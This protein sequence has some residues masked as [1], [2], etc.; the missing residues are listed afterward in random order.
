MRQSANSF[1]KLVA[2]AAVKKLLLKPSPRV[3]MVN[4]AVAVPS[5]F[6]PIPCHEGRYSIDRHGRVFTHIGKRLLSLTPTNAG[7]LAVK[8]VPLGRPPEKTLV[9]YLMIRTFATDFPDGAFV[10]HKNRCRSDNRI[11]NLRP[12]TRRQQCQNKSAV[13]QNQITVFRGVI[14]KYID[15]A[16][17]FKRWVATVRMPGGKKKWSK[18]FI[19]DRE[20]AL[21][22]D[23]MA[24]EFHGEFAITNKSLGLL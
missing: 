21:E 20:A 1:Q 5:G 17:A 13:K 2:Q 19:T 22:Y 11:T 16:A 24:V 12:A 14:L 4:G 8:L 18:Y 7:Y 23:R 3:K 9:Q 10:D 6:T 15:R